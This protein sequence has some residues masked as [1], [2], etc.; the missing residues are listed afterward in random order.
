MLLFA[1]VTVCTTSSLFVQ[2][3]V[4]LTPITTVIVAGEK[5]HG[6]DG[7]IQEL[8]PDEMFTYEHVLCVHATELAEEFVELDDE[9]ELDALVEVVVELAADDDDVGDFDE[10]EER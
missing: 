6:V 5:P 8:A 7:S 2:T 1:P 4:L 3:T 9:A 10:V